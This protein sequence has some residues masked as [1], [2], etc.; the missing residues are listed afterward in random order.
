MTKF[1]HYRKIKNGIPQSKGGVTVA[2]EVRPHN[3]VEKEVWYAY[4]YCSEDDNF[5]R[6]R[7]RCLATARLHDR[8]RRDAMLINDAKHFP[9]Y[10]DGVM[11]LRF[12]VERRREEEEEALPF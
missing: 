5:S 2:Y 10:M 6:P 12:G 1:L 3:P 4:A 11:A 7:G 9:T 8:H